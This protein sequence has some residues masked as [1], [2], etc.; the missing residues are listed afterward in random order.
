MRRLSVA[1][2][3]VGPGVRLRKGGAKGDPAAGIPG[4]D[5][6]SENDQ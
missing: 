3:A 4:R 5:A 2:S 6:N 1:E